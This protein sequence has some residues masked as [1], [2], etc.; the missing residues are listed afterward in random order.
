[1]SVVL[2][3]KLLKAV[4]QG[5]GVREAVPFGKHPRIG[6][7]AHKADFLPRT[8][9]DALLRELFREADF[10]GRQ[11]QQ[12]PRVGLAESRIL[13]GAR[14]A[15]AVGYQIAALGK[16]VGGNLPHL[17]E[18]E[19]IVIVQDTDAFK[20]VVRRPPRPHMGRP[21]PHGRRHL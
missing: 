16:D 17:V 20:P 6:R 18:N 8:R 2:A 15:H 10:P 19:Q 14:L 13:A 1:M 9:L 12:A 3:R 21:A 11:E 7:N 5:P 4:G